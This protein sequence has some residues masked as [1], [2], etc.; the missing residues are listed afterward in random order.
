MIVEHHRSLLPLRRASAGAGRRRPAARSRRRPSWPSARG[1][2]AWPST[3][4]RAPT[5]G[6]RRSP[7]NLAPPC[8]SRQT[9]YAPRAGP[10]SC[11]ASPSAAAA[12]WAGTSP[13]CVIVLVG[14]VG[15]VF[16]VR[17]NEDAGER[18]R[19]RRTR[20]PASCGDHW[21]AAL[22][23]EHLRRVALR[24]PEF[25]T[26]ADNPACAPGIHT[27]GDG[28]IHI[29]PFIAR[30]RPA[31]T[32][33]SGSSSAT[34][35]G[36]CRRTRSTRG[37]GRR[38]TPRR[39]SGRTATRARCRR[40]TRARR[41]SCAGR[42]TARSATGNPADYKLAGRRRRSPIAFLPE[43]RGDRLRRA[44]RA[45]RP[46]SDSADPSEP[47]RHADARA[48]R[49]PP[50]RDHRHAAAGVDDGDHDRAATPRREGGRPRR[51]RGHPAAAAHVHHAEAAAAR[52]PTSR[53]SSAS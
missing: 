38:P 4:L 26:V 45:A 14:V 18:R 43:G 34:A 28:V 44:S 41:A 1:A 47:D 23:V 50:C 10:G 25:E 49:R 13:S 2:G 19:C 5:A 6:C 16:T 37:R 31:T 40:A 12:P 17:D 9:R 53:S 29:H 46:S 52:S 20:P 3:R 33:R 32:P 30:P 39:R 22:D 7:G 11:T 15:I 24:P 42:S 51:R 35:A 36:A 27:H 21:H 8:P 48:R